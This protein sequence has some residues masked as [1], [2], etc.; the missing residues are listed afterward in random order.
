MNIKRTAVLLGKEFIHGPKSFMFVWAVI[1]PIGFTLIATLA[2]GTLFSERPKLGIYDK[3]DSQLVLNIQ[4]L[5]SITTK[6]YDNTSELKQATENGSVDIGIVL[7]TSFDDAVKQGESVTIE[8][9]IW[10]ESL[11]KNRTIIPVT[12]ADLVRALAGQEVPVEIESVTLGEETGIPWNERLLPFLV[13]MGVFFGGLMLPSTSLIDEK[14]KK[15]LEALVI[16]PASIGDIFISKAILGIVLSTF[17]GIAILV[18]NNAF[19]ANSPLLVMVLLFGA[20]MAAELGL[21]AGALIKDITTLF[22]I[23][24]SGG[25]FLF[26]PVFIYM[27]PQIP[28]WIAKIFPTYYALQPVVEISLQGGGWSGISTNFFILVGL[29]IALIGVIILVLKKSRQFRS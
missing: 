23:W 20:I 9:Y 25:I 16:T 10:G 13:L 7:P 8:G 17:M 4:E 1:A 3:G 18:L 6:V 12:I 21:I 19:G 2:F 29:D 24:K 27:F 22:T 11:A 28:E 15:T 26:A 5:D 14:Q